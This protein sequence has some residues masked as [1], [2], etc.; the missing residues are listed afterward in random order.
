MMNYFREFLL[1]FSN[2][3]EILF[4]QVRRRIFHLKLKKTEAFQKTELQVNRGKQQKTISENK[5]KL[6]DAESGEENRVSLQNM[7]EGELE[8]ATWKNLI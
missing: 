5:K 2:D 7:H 3:K 6:H 1:S 4:R 8:I